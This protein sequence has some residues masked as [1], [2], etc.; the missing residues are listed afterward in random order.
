[1]HARKK[2]CCAACP[3]S[4]AVRP[5]TSGACPETSGN[6][7]EELNYAMGKAL[8]S[9][10]YKR[11]LLRFTAHH[12]GR[13][14]GRLR[15]DGCIMLVFPGFMAMKNN[16]SGR[17]LIFEAVAFQSASAASFFSRLIFWSYPG[18]SYDMLYWVIMV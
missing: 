9:L 6:R 11:T 14:D 4:S 12:G 18:D 10:R 13:V 7:G 2:W 1:M 8:L 5:E 15:L 3:E 17:K 16:N